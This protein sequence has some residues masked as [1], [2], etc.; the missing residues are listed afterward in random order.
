MADQTVFRAVILF[1][2]A[3]SAECEKNLAIDWLE[4]LVCNWRLRRLFQGRRNEANIPDH[5]V[6]MFV[7]MVTLEIMA[8]GRRTLTSLLEIADEMGQESAG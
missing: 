1:T 2:G 8:S 4:V 5:T 7:W 6:C 3:E